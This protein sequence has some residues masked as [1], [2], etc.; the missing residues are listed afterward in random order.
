ML[1]D[2]QL[3]AQAGNINLGAAGQFTNLS[4]ITI[5]GLI[6][7]A[8]TLI[9]IAAALVFFFMLIIGGIKW[10]TSGGDKGQT[11]AARNQITAALI[12]LFVV[13]ASYAIISLVQI[14]F[15]INILNLNIPTA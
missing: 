5:T 15:A 9:L 3:L 13:F 2:M 1:I 4:H 6:S 10:I 14:F 7:A 11:E 12:G 8:V